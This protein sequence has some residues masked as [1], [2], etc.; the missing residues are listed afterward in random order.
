MIKI[1]KLTVEN[2]AEGCV[3]DNASP[4][5]SFALSSDDND[6]SLAEAV[7][8][9]GDWRVT[10]T[11]QIAVPYDGAP[12][13]SFTK[14]TVKVRVT[15]SLGAIAERSAQFE[16]GRLGTAW[17]A[18]WISDADYKFT[19]KRV[20]P[21]PMV[22]RKRLALDKKI[23]RAAVYCTAMGIY[24]LNIDG[25]KV[26]GDYFAPGFTSYKTR[27]QY[28]T[29]DVTDML[30]GNSELTATVAGGWAVGSFVFTRKNRITADRQ[31]L[32]LELRVTYADGSEEIV[33]TDESWQVTEDGNYRAADFY[34]G[35]TYDATIPPDKIVWR[36]ASAE[37]LRV[38]PTILAEYGAPVRGHEVMK[39]VSV[40]RSDGGE[41]VYDFGQNFAGVIRAKIKGKNGQTVVFRHAE[42]LK[43]NGELFTE[44]LRSAK[45][46]ATYICADGGQTFSPRFTYMGFRYVG[47]SGIDE[48]DLELTAVALYSELADNGSFECSNELINKLQSNIRWSA[49]S[50]F[51]DIPTDCPQRDERMGWTGDIALFARTACYNFDMSRFLDKWLTDVKAEQLKSGGIPNT[52]PVQGYG[53]PATM[54]VMAVDFWG[55]ACVLVPWAEYLARG[56][57]ELLRKMYPTMKKYVKACKFW[58]GLLSVG[59]RRYIWNTPGV[60]HFGDWVAPGVPKMS[61]WQARRTW[62]ATASLAN[63]SGLLAR[64]AGLLGETADEKYYTDLNA[65]VKDAY[66]SVLTDGKGKLL[67]EFQTAYVLPLQFGIFTEG[68]R[69][70]AADN[71][72]ALVEKADYCIGTGFP[73]TPYLLFALA[74][75]GRGDVAFKMLTNTKCPSWLFEVK[76]GGTTVW[77]RWDALKEDGTSNTGAEDGTGGMVSFNHYAA[78]AVGDFLYRRVA[79]IEP[80]EAG[81]KRFRVKP[82][83]G[84]GITYARGSVETPYGTI[85]S[86]WKAEAGK[87]SLAVS[88]PVN[89][90]CEIVLPNGTSKTVGSGEY[91]AECVM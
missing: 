71:L 54:P 37:K 86:D 44:L 68:T 35:E 15:D 23:A 78:G 58:A 42:I 46:T 32:L 26:G 49:K 47:V 53:F 62:T 8:S 11:E 39:P 64:I 88:V 41:L 10:T 51:I 63:T 34:D 73:G 87:F 56:D 59:K 29:Y 30:T 12:L 65:K 14:Y 38:S 76:A 27:L 16:T 75:N 84:G 90:V 72:A 21:V 80:V 69:Q 55:D 85:T 45:A 1:S 81:Y 6:V 17:R 66:V 19:E 9:V 7:I 60:F 77:E 79:G 18:K 89:T 4:R 83:V 33:G 57:V 67:E 20:S 5:F 70:A 61:Q 36:N 28:Q 74:D 2:L 91:T 3:T 82:L 48:S 25:K 31:A 50:N 22:F 13:A 40:K 52:V 43:T 24:E